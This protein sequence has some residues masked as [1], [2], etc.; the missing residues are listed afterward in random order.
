MEKIIEHHDIAIQIPLKNRKGLPS[1]IDSQLELL[2]TFKT[3]LRMILLLTIN[4][5]FKYLGR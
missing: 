3:L 1:I 2:Q 4:V 5:E